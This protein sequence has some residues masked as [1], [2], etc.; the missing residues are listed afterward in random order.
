VAVALAAC[1][2][3]RE[4]SPGSARCVRCHFGAEDLPAAASAGAHAAHLR[5]LSPEL[6]C[7]SC[8][9][10]PRAGSATHGDGRVDVALGALATNGGAPAHLDPQTLACTS[11]YCHGA[12][13]GGSPANA[14]VWT[15]VGAGQADCGT[16][17]PLPPADHLPGVPADPAACGACHAG[18]VDP[19]GQILVG[20]GHVNGAVDRSDPAP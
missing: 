7:A 17:H 15:A 1:G 19:A 16:C 2:D 12:F 11:V 3:A 8:H 4:V 13:A 9:P 18:T 14:P 10:D 6:V 20:G 5:A